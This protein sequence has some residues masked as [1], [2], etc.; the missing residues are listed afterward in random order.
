VS[1][2]S[3]QLVDTSLFKNVREDT[4]Q[5]LLARFSTRT[6][7]PSEVVFEQ[8][9]PGDFLVVI[10]KGDFELLRQGATGEVHL[11]DLGPGTVL[12]HVSLVDGG[13]RSATL[14]AHGDGTIAILDRETFTS[15][16]EDPSP[17]A[18]QLQ[19]RVTQLVIEELR[20]ANR[21]LTDLLDVPL[22]DTPEA[23]QRLLGVVDGAR[24]R[25][26]NR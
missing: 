19:L 23:I 11:A 24:R 12:G 6:L 13:P 5:P 20:V 9:D 4:V 1:S 18:V 22:S 8:G 3:V 7:T 25:T 16:W 10:T 14:R 26:G 17:D 21:K 2:D 15:L